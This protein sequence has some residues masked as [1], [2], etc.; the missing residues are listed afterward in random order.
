WFLEMNTAAEQLL[1]ANVIDFISNWQSMRENSVIDFNNR[2]I[3]VDTLKTDQATYLMLFD[4]RTHVPVEQVLEAHPQ[5]LKQPAQDLMAVKAKSTAMI[6]HQFGTPI[7]AVRLKSYLLKK[8]LDS[9]SKERI[10][11]HLDQIEAQLDQMVDLLDDLMLVNQVYSSEQIAAFSPVDLESFCKKIVDQMTLDLDGC[12]IVLTYSGR[13]SNV[14]LDRRLVRYV[15]SNLIGCLLKYSGSTANLD[16]RRQGNTVMF[17]VSAPNIAIPAHDLN[18]LFSQSHRINSGMGL[19]L[20][21]MKTCIE[22]YGGTISAESNPGSGTNFVV[23][24]PCRDAR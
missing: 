2:N 20:S 11:E 1:G 6:A 12:E 4:D 24:L 5:E 13:M 21:I 15:L 14:Q 3:R 10:T 22:M 16:V 18:E 17:S 19:G 9:L 7:S 23:S 8:H